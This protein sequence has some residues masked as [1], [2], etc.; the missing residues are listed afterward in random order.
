MPN[1]VP[2]RILIIDDDALS[3]ELLQLLLSR[4][5][6][7]VEAAESGEAAL[8]IMRRRQ[9][10]DAV[11]ADL[12]MPGIRGADLALELRKACAPSSRLIAISASSSDELEGYDAFLLK[13]FPAEALATVLTGN[14]APAL[15]EPI[16]QNVPI[17]DQTVYDKLASSMQPERVN[18]LYAFCLADAKKRVAAM[19]EAAT[20]GDDATYRREAHAIKGGTGMVGAVELQTIASTMEDRGIPANYLATLDEFLIACDRVERMLLAHKTEPT[21]A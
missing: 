18:Q 8:E 19:R 21:T 17:L 15:N 11:L 1:K 20:Q 7:E 2:I 13:P 5:G 12:Q 3:R 6:Y 14:P 9:A 4:E 10:P 16:R